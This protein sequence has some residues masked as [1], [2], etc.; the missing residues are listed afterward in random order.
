[1]SAD[2]L[3]GVSDAAHTIA[4]DAA[5]LG[6]DGVD[7]QAAAGALQQAGDLKAARTAFAALSDAVVKKFSCSSA[8]CADVS[9]A[10]CPMAHKYWL[11]KGDTIQNPFYG[12][13]MSD[14]GRFTS[15]VTHS[16]K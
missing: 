5:R 3:A 9:V 14:C 8:A 16:Q 13:Q 6:A 10:Y 2:T 4:I 1:L 11:Q 12:L 7:L 15:D